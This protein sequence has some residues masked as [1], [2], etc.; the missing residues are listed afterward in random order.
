MQGRHVSFSQHQEAGVKWRAEELRQQHAAEEAAAVQ[1]KAEVAA[2]R[3]AEPVDPEAL[4]RVKVRGTDDD[5]AAEVSQARWEAGVR[6]DA[7][8]NGGIVPPKS[9]GNSR[10]PSVR[11]FAAKTLPAPAD[12]ETELNGLIAECRFL[13]REVAYNSACLTYDPEDRIRY[14]TS[15]QNM[16]LTGAKVGETV[17]KLRGG[18]E[19]AVET[20]RHELVYTH[21]QASQLRASRDPARHPL[22][23]TSARE[24]DKQ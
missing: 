24:S 11:L 15:A 19:P 21:V 23:P 13:M 1:A 9:S 17:A 18:G 7:A 14:L 12:T 2:A 3:A 20:R 16:A 8:V 4:A 6:T 22:P 10:Y 5:E